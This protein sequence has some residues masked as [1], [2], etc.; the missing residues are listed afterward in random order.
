MRPIAIIGIVLI[1]LGLG[2]LVVRNVSFTT[3]ER[4]L[5]I[6]PIEATAE[7]EHSIAVPE[8]ASIAAILVGGFLVFVGR[9]RSR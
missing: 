3:E 2:A 9:G 8:I 7:K 1:V 4:V 5:D 6:G